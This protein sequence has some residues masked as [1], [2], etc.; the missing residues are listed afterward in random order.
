MR[1]PPA[2]PACGPARRAAKE[3][4]AALTALALYRVHTWQMK[5][6][7]ESLGAKMPVGPVGIDTNGDGVIDS[8]AVDTNGDGNADRIISIAKTPMTPVVEDVP[9]ILA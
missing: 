8:V 2:C 6:G 5:Q 4:Q 7:M 1:Q 9:T 3:A